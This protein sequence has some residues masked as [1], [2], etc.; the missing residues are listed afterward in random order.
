M[1]HCPAIIQALFQYCG[2]SITGHGQILNLVG[3]IPGLTL[4]NDGTVAFD[5]LDDFITFHPRLTV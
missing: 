2:Y 1:V 3:D 4:N 5:P